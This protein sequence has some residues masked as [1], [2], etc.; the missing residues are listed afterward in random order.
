MNLAKRAACMWIG[1]VAIGSVG[2]ASEIADESDSLEDELPVDGEIVSKSQAL[3]YGC[4]EEIVAAY[5]PGRG[6]SFSR[7][8]DVGLSGAA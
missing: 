2:C 4:P 6:G 1:A 3:S 8:V 7:Q 5:S